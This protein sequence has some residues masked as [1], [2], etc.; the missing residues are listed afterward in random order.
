IWI[1]LPDN[2]PLSDVVVRTTPCAGQVGVHRPEHQVELAGVQG[3]RRHEPTLKPPRLDGPERWPPLVVGAG[4]GVDMGQGP[5]SLQLPDPHRPPQ[6]SYCR[7][8]LE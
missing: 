2:G 7:L 8:L 3:G 6:L 4:A 1:T 5:A